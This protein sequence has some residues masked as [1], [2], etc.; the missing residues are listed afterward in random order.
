[1]DTMTKLLGALFVADGRECV[2]RGATP[3]GLHMFT[4]GNGWMFDLPDPAT[5][6]PKWPTTAQVTECRANNGDADSQIGAVSL[7]DQCRPGQAAET[8]LLLVGES[9]CGQ[10][11][12]K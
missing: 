7:P 6:V 10:Q 9:V 8:A 2:Y 12:S 3:L 1:M 11:R 4:D 5:G